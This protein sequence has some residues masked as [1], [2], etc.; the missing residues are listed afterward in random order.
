MGQ[1]CPG[2]LRASEE[3]VPLSTGLYHQPGTCGL[4]WMAS[5]G[6]SVPLALHC[7]ILAFAYS[8]AAVCPH[9]GWPSVVSVCARPRSALRGR[10]GPDR[11]LRRGLDSWVWLRLGLLHL[12]LVSVQK[13]AKDAIG[14]YRQGLSCGFEP[15]SLPLSQKRDQRNHLK[16][17]SNPGSSARVVK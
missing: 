11:G 4:S 10:G 17:N 7:A 9:G 1:N 3:E 5:S 16:F 2:L 14:R 8:L 6:A 12:L 13:D 15:R